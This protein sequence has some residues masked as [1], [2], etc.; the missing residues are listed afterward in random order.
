MNLETYTSEGDLYRARGPD[1][2]PSR[3]LFA[4]DVFDKARI[5]GSNH[6]G[7]VVVMSHPCT[8]RGANAQIRESLLVAPIS[9]HAPIPRTEW[10]SRHFKKSPF[11]EIEIGSFHVAHLDEI[12]R[13]LTSD[14]DLQSRQACLS[15]FGLN[16]LQQ[17]LIWNLTRFRIKTSQLARAFAHTYEEA[18]LLEDW[19]TTLSDVELPREAATTLFEEFIREPRTGD[20]SYQEQL[21]EP[22]QR[23]TVRIACRNES[24]KIANE[25][26]GT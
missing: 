10:I 9:T 11:P 19:C 5:Q 21:R 15:E 7:L 23:S 14:L 16:L 4:G 25:R 13:S 17:R 24:R 18:E 22:Q 6:V 8:F 3:P 2:N 12:G 20:R 1:V 26:R